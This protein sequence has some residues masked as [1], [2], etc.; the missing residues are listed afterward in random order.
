MEPLLDSGVTRGDVLLL[1]FILEIQHSLH[2]PNGSFRIFFSELNG[3]NSN[4]FGVALVWVDSPFGSREDLPC[5][6]ESSEEALDGGS[7]DGFA[8]GEKDF[9][10][11]LCPQIILSVHLDD[12]MAESGCQRV[13]TTSSPQSG[14]VSA[15]GHGSKSYGGEERKRKFEARK[16]RKKGAHF[17]FS[18]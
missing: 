10:D 15:S 1:I 12:T 17:E 8:S 14:A 11:F 16:N 6:I 9:R 5:P 4:I 7:S 3:A 13:L 18:F 2:I